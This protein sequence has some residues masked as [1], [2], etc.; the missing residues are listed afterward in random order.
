MERW[1]KK[2]ITQKYGYGQVMFANS[3]F[4]KDP[5]LDNNINDL[6]K[7]KKLIVFSVLFE[8]QDFALELKNKYN[9]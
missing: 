7:I 2:T 8:Q 3:L 5:I 9:I 1:G 6:N 4:L